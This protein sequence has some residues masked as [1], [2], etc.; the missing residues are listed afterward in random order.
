MQRIQRVIIDIFQHT[1]VRGSTVV[2]VG[3]MV[4]NVLA[5]VFHLIVGR[6]LEPAQ[7]GEFT[8]LL[9]LFY[10]INVGSQ[11]V[12]TSLVKFFS[13]LRA[14]GKMG[15]SRT[16][17]DKATRKL[18]LGCFIGLVVAALAAKPLGRFLHINDPMYFIWLYFIFALY[19]LTIVPISAL[20]AFQKFTASLVLVNVGASLRLLFGIVG[21][22][23][24]VAWV[25]IGN[26]ASN[27]ITY[28]LYFIP[29]GF[30]V[31]IP[32]RPLSLTRKGMLSY[33]M[34]TLATTLGITALYSQD[35]LVVKHFFSPT[36]AGLYASL[37]VL[38]KV[39]YYT[40]AA[41]AFVLFPIVAERKERKQ[42]HQRVVW[43][44]LGVVGLLSFVLSTLYFLFP[45]T[46]IH[47]LFGTAYDGAI[48]YV[49]QFGLFISFF[50]L[51]SILTSVSLAAGKTRVWMFTALAAGVQLTLLWFVHASL[52]TVIWINVVV[53]A[54][55]F[56]ALLLYYA[57]AK[58]AS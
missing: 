16:L 55:L 48:P 37:S 6:L 12:Q 7:Y 17:F 11:V 9:S 14:Q 30:L 4:A 24:G 2:L 13:T 49:G 27:A 29:L 57:H 43:G 50:T 20:Q 33:S 54:A 5:Y 1:V 56:V 22:Y 38:G 52:S 35:V 44:A 41:I 58:N 8:A 31:R 15:E 51:A 3:S 47:L 32:P 39:I 23:F 10:I 42:D 28:V 26:I 34:P 45:T 36:D 25:L 18:I 46:A 21:A 19:V 53:A 40:S